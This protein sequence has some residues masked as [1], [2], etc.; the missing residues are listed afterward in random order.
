MSQAV[1]GAAGGSNSLDAQPP[2]IGA[3]PSLGEGLRLGVRLA[4]MVASTML[5]RVQWWPVSKTTQV[6]GRIESITPGWV[7]G[8]L[9]PHL[10]GA[11][12]VMVSVELHSA[13]TSV[14]ARLRLRYSPINDTGR[15]PATV[16]VKS[17]PSLVTRIGNGLTGTAPAEAGFYNELRNLFDLEAPR[18]YYSATEPHSGRAVHLLE[19]LVATRQATFCEP[20]TVI[21]RQQAELIVDQL[22]R[23][24]ARGANLELSDA[25]KPRWLRSYPHWWAVTGSISAIRRYHLR[26]QRRA[27]DEGLTP[28]SLVGRG[29]QLWR[30][31]EAS[32]HAHCGLP[33]TL[34][35]GDPHLGNWFV[36]GA[37]RMGLADW[38]CISTGHWSRDLSYAIASA[39]SVDQRRDWEHALLDRYLDRLASEGGQALPRAQAWNLYRQQLVGALAMW[40]TTL[41]PPRFLPAMQPKSTSAEMLR[42]ILTAI[43]DHD[44][45]D[46]P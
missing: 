2:A 39:L 34:I 31:F 35:H 7:S 22:A 19:D 28:P 11:R 14:R 33:R 30:S 38:Q 6:P 13:G 3:V 45:L 10:G 27:D 41:Y 23:L 1:T 43:D 4:P 15:L 8:V 5:D 9:R 32:V 44:A 26:G 46:V 29:E 24:H 42:R 17:T 20:T 12:V 21:S 40:T 36:T 25:L 18:G 16:F 37:G